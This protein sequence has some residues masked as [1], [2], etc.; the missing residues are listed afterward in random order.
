MNEINWTSETNG[1]EFY[2]TITGVTSPN[3][4]TPAKCIELNIKV[5]RDLVEFYLDGKLFM[6]A[7]WTGE[8]RPRIIRLL[9]SVPAEK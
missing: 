9:A 3:G 7:D 1:E 8:V 6:L 5:A 2:L 4:V